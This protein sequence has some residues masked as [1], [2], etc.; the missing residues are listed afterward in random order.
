MSWRLPIAPRLA[1]TTG[2]AALNCDSSWLEQPHLGVRS[3]RSQ[4]PPH[5]P[6]AQ[7]PVVGRKVVGHLQR[8]FQRHVQPEVAGVGKEPERHDHDLGVRQRTHDHQ[9]D[10]SRRLHP[11]RYRWVTIDH[12]LGLRLGQVHVRY[13][14]DAGR[15]PVLGR[16]F[17]E[18]FQIVLNHCSET[19]C[20]RSAT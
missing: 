17:L 2:V 19:S 1:L 8:L 10:R 5:R 12:L 14:E 15:R 13:V 20:G 4:A 11:L 7:G 16:R 6:P 18:G 9:R 3:D